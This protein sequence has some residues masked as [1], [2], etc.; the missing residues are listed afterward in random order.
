MALWYN[1]LNNPNFESDYFKL[2]EEYSIHSVAN[3]W[4]Y[5]NN[6]AALG[7]DSHKQTRRLLPD[8]FSQWIMPRSKGFTK[9]S[10]KKISQSVWVYV[11]S[12]LILQVQA[13]SGIGKTS[14]SPLDAKQIFKSTFT[15][16]INM[17]FSVADEFSRYQGVFEHAQL[18]VDFSVE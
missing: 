4:F 10:L 8:N 12:A 7:P 13:R 11:Y 18:K 1:K 9:T 2:Y 16:L 3:D 5:T 15:E 17:G 6:V 14:A